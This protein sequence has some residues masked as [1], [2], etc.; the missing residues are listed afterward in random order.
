MYKTAEGKGENKYGLDG[1]AARSKYLP[2]Q[3]CL[4]RLL[5]LLGAR[6]AALGGLA[7][8]ERETR[9]TGRPDTA[10]GA[11]VSHLQSSRFHPH[12][13]RPPTPC[14]V[15]SYLTYSRAD[16][17]GTECRLRGSGLAD[18]ADTFVH[19]WVAAAW[20]ADSVRVARLSGH[21]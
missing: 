13:L 16:S 5:R 20:R 11:R 8:P 17:P 6:L 1:S 2:W 9:P 15:S 19:D 12:R 18:R 10:A 14:L 21:G 7:L 4:A 3:W